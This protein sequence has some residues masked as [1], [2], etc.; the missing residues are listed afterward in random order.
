MARSVLVWLL[1]SDVVSG[2]LFFFFFFFF[3]FSDADCSSLFLFDFCFFLESP[4][5]ETSDAHSG[6]L[7]LY[8]VCTN[9]LNGRPQLVLA[10]A[11]GACY[12]LRFV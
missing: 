2:G 11:A 10:V 3:F 12:L 7:T 5:P 1:F 9:F 8:S 4:A 6:T